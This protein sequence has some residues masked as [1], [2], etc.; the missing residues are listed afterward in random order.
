MVLLHIKVP[1]GHRGYLVDAAAR[2]CTVLFATH[3]L[4]EWEGRA[5]RCLLVEN[6][7]SQGELPPA[8]LRRAF[9]RLALAS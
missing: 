7:R 8:E 6:G 3:L 1:P 2:G 4:G 5:D 9:P